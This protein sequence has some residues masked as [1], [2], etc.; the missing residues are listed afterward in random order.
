MARAGRQRPLTQHL[1]DLESIESSERPHL[2]PTP[3]ERPP[4]RSPQHPSLEHQDRVARRSVTLKAESMTEL[5]QQGSHPLLCAQILEATDGVDQAG[6]D[7]D[8][9]SQQL[10]A[11]RAL[12]TAA[13]DV[14]VGPGLWIVDVADHQRIRGPDGAH[15]LCRPDRDDL[16]HGLHGLLAAEALRMCGDPPRPVLRRATRGAQGY[17]LQTAIDGRHPGRQ[18]RTVQRPHL[19]AH[20]D[21]SSRRPTTGQQ[22]ESPVL[23]G[24]KWRHVAQSLLPQT[25]A[26]RVH[27][28]IQHADIPSALERH[29]ARPHEHA[30]Q[31]GHRADLLSRLPSDSRSPPQ[32]VSREPPSP[33]DHGRSASRP[34][35]RT[36]DGRGASKPKTRE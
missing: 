15:R 17:A 22:H 28:R 11:P 34:T 18:P 30:R 1:P 29:A 27:Q 6:A 33:R 24:R 13:G 21:R 10:T 3:G 7:P 14:G 35:T 4:A 9:R 31:P 36:R 5:M 23:P 16:D 26:L 19:C 2:D 20:R 12:P 8:L 32:P 25:P